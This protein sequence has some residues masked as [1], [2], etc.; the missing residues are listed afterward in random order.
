MDAKRWLPCFTVSLLVMGAVAQSEETAP[1]LRH[2]RDIT[3]GLLQPAASV[4]VSAITGQ[5]VLAVAAE[6]EQL[7]R[8]RW[9][10]YGGPGVAAG[11]VYGRAAVGLTLFAGG[12]YYF[13]P[14]AP[15]GAWVGPEVAG[16]WT[17]NLAAHS[18]L[19]ALSAY[20][21]YNLLLGG[22]FLAS[23]GGGVTFRAG[24]FGSGVTP[25]LRVNVGHTF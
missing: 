25:A 20:G 21:G 11:T 5:A 24:G 12:R 3:V 15:G 16:T 7:F 19:F 13:Q 4:A 2:S 22:G 1:T 9:A 18:T 6:Y 23:F 8:H 14:Q 10:V 17:S